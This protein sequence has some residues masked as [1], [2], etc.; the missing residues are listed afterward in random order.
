[1]GL[2][3]KNNWPEIMLAEID[4]AS[5]RG[6]VWGENDCCLF[7]CNVIL[8]MT[9]T[10]PAAWFRGKYSS[11]TWATRRLREFAGGGLLEAAHK[12][13]HD[14]D[15][16]EMSWPRAMRGDVAYYDAARLPALG[17]V[18]GREVVFV[19]PDAGIARRPISDMHTVWRV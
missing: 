7:V 12:I 1:M 16:P 5:K 6:F 11:A 17:L 14:L 9:G 15:M 18:T 19:A 10:D 2:Q 13:T 4:A 3:R 8:A